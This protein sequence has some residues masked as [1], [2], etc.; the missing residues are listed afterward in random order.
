MIDEIDEEKNVNIKKTGCSC[1]VF[2]TLRYLWT[3]NKLYDVCFIVDKSQF[4]CHKL[5][6]ITY[7]P[8]FRLHLINTSP[9]DL[10][11]VK[12]C[13]STKKGIPAIIRYIYTI[14]INI[15][16]LNFADTLITSYELGIENLVEK[17]ENFI[18]E[19]LTTNIN[20][21]QLED[22][23]KILTL[24]LSILYPLKQKDFYKK[25]MSHVAENFNYVLRNVE[26]LALDV[27][28]FYSLLKFYPITI[29]KE[30]DLFNGILKWIR[31]DLT[32]RS[33]YEQ[34]MMNL[35]KFQ[36]IS[37][38]DIEKYV[39]TKDF[40]MDDP[41]IKEKVKMSLKYVIFYCLN[42]M[43]KLLSLLGH[44]FLGNLD[45]FLPRP[46]RELFILDIVS[47]WPYIGDEVAKHYF[48]GIMFLQ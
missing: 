30:V 34:L 23:I 26:F 1:K 4:Y 48:F 8:P 17:C 15:D 27:K 20:E 5:A 45:R 11:Q 40:I 42:D 13:Y 9:K 24:A 28:I 31:K 16:L 19:S 46:I 33:K 29:N 3:I 22:S 12:L 38:I 14:E 36:F 37:P 47:A 41:Y 35:I 44:S 6:V 21:S 10:V 39:E 43:F 18:I 32:K 25:I 7:C 2:K